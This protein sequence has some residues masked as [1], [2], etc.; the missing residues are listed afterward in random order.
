MTYIS[1]RQKVHVE[2]VTLI[3]PIMPF[4]GMPV[5][6]TEATASDPAPAFIEYVLDTWKRSARYSE[7]RAAQRYLRNA[8]DIFD[9]KRTMIGADGEHVELKNMANNRLA[10]PFFRKLVK[11]KVNYLLSN[12]PVVTSDNSSLEDGV[13]EVMTKE[14]IR[15]LKNG[16]T[17]AISQGIG[18]LQAYYTE[19]GK[20]SFKRIPSHE[21]IPFWSDV[22]H[23]K[24]VAVIRFFSYATFDNGT[25]NLIERVQYYTARGIFNY[26]RTANNSFSLDR[27]NPVTFNYQTVSS[28]EVD[29]NGVQVEDDSNSEV[30]EDHMWEKIPFIPIKYNEEEESLLQ[31]IRSL[32]D[33]YD[34]RA[35]DIANALEEEPDKVKIV[36]NYDGTDKQE[37]V[38]NLATYRT[39][40]VRDNG[41]LTTL[42]TSVDISAEMANLERLRKD[43]YDFG[44]GVDTQSTDLGNASG[45]ALKFRYA[46]LDLDC[47][48]LGSELSW[49]FE[50]IAWF[51]AQD[52]NLQGSGNVD[53]IV[54]IDVNFNTSIMVN[55]KEQIDSVKASVDIVSQ[56][57]LL[58]HHPFVSDVQ[59]EL[60]QLTEEQET[61]NEVAL[62]SAK[63]F[64]ALNP[65]GE[66]AP[67]SVGEAP[68]QTNSPLTE[69]P[70]EEFEG[71]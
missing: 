29:E 36:K 39:A 59:A 30:V 21:V 50:Q 7:M 56:K 62:E 22:D 70:Q 15:N 2:D 10:H 41:D 46:D 63:A 19:D 32:I 11:Q 64:Q 18:W 40:F 5:E 14:F 3:Q 28:L 55:E 53:E 65:L 27:S 23:T 71:V 61:A 16:T 13:N 57:T 58:E 12:A 26:Q 37:F 66:L 44:N 35:S 52:L 69:E 6:L 31:L 4:D 24:L 68:H 42:D 54:D 47:K 8:N 60:D 1:E 48:D 45:V 51:V 20:L 9:R 33:A 67:R 17:N 34:R 38:F 43:I 25:P 49:T